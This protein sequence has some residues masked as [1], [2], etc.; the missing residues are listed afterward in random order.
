[1]NSS[2]FASQLAT[3]TEVSSLDSL[4]TGFNSLSQVQQLTG[5]SDLIGRTVTYTPTGSTTPAAG[6]VSGLTV[7]NGIVN[8]TIN[9]TDVPINQV[10]GVN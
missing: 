5:A 6:V 9:N 1:M 3:L 8:L 7:Q 4:S 10:N 2:D